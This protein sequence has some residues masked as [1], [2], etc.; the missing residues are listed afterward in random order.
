MAL[1]TTRFDVQDHLTTPEQCAL[2]LEAMLE[3]E[4]LNAGEIAMALRDVANSKGMSELARATGL[5][6]EALYKALSENGNPT[7]TTVVAVLK[8]FG[9]R[10]A[11]QPVQGAGTRSKAA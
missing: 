11:V 2:Y 1:N 8:A 10:L 4:D 9:L 6:R 5:T 3:E 7:L